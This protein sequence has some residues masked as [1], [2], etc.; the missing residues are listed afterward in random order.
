MP[1]LIHATPKNRK[2]RASGQAVVTIQGQDSC[3]G[4]WKSKASLVEYDH[5]IAAWLAN[6]RQ[7]PIAVADRDGL[8]M[9]ELLARYW[10]SPGIVDARKGVY[11]TAIP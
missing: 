8:T 9:S 5:L 2:H 11:D 4:P 3:L 10:P 6:G 7:A 1:R